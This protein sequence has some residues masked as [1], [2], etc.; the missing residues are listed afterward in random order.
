MTLSEFYMMT[1]R[2]FFIYVEGHSKRKQEEIEEYNAKFEIENKALIYQAYLISRWVWA[3]K[4]DIESILDL[5]K[6]KNVMTDEEMLAQ[7]KVL[8][9]LFGGEVNTCNL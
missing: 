5:K 1:P 6:E 2:E 9:N 7:V 4:V 3:K 8:N